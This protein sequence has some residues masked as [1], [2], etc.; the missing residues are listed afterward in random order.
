MRRFVSYDYYNWIIGTLIEVN[1]IRAK[2]L[3]WTIF[4]I[5]IVCWQRFAAL[6]SAIA[7]YSLRQIHAASL[8]LLACYY[9]IK[10]I[11]IFSAQCKF[12]QS[13]WQFSLH[14]HTSE[15]RRTVYG[16]EG[17]EK[18]WEK[19]D[20]QTIWW[21]FCLFLSLLMTDFFFLLHILLCLLTTEL[22]VQNWNLKLD[23]CITC[24]FEKLEFLPLNSYRCFCF[25]FFLKLLLFKSFTNYIKRAL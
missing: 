6:C 9:E 18:L 10:L 16:E 1:W 21:C 12:T 5:H 3:I 22:S 4:P 15:M 8:F 20:R 14:Q 24:I 11:N 25:L 13:H 19:C 23:I 7:P 17:E 2:R